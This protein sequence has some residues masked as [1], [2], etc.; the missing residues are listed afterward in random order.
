MITALNLHIF[1]SSIG[2]TTMKNCFQHLRTVFL[3]LLFLCLVSCG[4]KGSSEN[5]VDSSSST[6]S[7]QSALAQQLDKYLQD[8]QKDG[9]AGV[10]IMVF[11]NGETVYA[12]KGMANQNTHTK[13]TQKTGFRLASVSKPFTAIAIMQLVEKGELNLSDSILKYIPE[14][15]STWS[16]IT[17]EHLLTHRSGIY[18]ILN[19][20][21]NPTLINGLTN[22][23]L[24]PYLRQNPALEFTPGTKGDYSN[25]GHMLLAVI[26]ERKTGLTFPKYM[27]LNIFGPA[28]M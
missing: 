11:K 4:G 22:E 9:E 13:I 8:N 12:S 20:F 28:N 16:D 5:Q 6:T 26:I 23:S 1:F 15:S 10:S 17:I 27:A 21:W 18:D 24:I 2:S 19:D 14:L 3:A 25:T 7:N